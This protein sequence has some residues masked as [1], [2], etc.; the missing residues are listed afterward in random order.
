MSAPTLTTI[1]QRLYDDVEPLASQDA[2]NGYALALFAAGLAKMLDGVAD[3]TRDTDT[4]VGWGSVMNADA[5]PVEW[6]PWLAQFL[7]VTLPGTLTEQQRRDRIKG[8]DGFKRGTPAAMK[9]AAQALLT[10]TRTVFFNERSGN[11]YRLTVSTW[12]SE[13]PDSAKVLAA[14]VAQKPAGIVLTYSTIVGGDWATL[15][16]TH[17]TWTATLASFATWADLIADPAHI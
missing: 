14:L 9:V 16:G 2:A 4:M 3:L 5:A 11:A 15:V 6:L 10:G 12:A 1:G 7:G 13:T 8:T 17:A